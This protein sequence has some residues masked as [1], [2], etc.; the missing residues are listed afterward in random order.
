MDAKRY[1]TCELYRG[2]GMPDDDQKQNRHRMGGMQCGDWHM[3]N[4]QESDLLQ[5]Q[6]DRPGRGGDGPTT[7]ERADCGLYRQ[8]EGGG[9]LGRVKYETANW[10]DRKVPDAQ[11]TGEDEAIEVWSYQA[12][13]SGSKSGYIGTS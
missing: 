1:Y 2:V 11:Q 12:E 7:R 10:T 13:Y 3:G 6:C 9:K 4:L 5:M 8:I